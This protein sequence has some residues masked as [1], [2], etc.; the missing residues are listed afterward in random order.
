MLRHLFD[1]ADMNALA[2]A[3]IPWGGGILLPV[4]VSNQHDLMQRTRYA[5]R[6]TEWPADLDPYELPQTARHAR[7]LYVAEALSRWAHR[8]VT[9]LKNLRHHRH[10]AL[11]GG[12]S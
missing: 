5:G 1:P 3:L 7:S 11:A 8:A 9:A 10:A 6:F 12:H 4:E 2:R